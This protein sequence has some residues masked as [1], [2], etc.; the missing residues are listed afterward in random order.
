[1]IWDE[2]GAGQQ[3]EPAFQITED[4]QELLTAGFVDRRDDQ[5]RALRP[6]ASAG[7]HKRVPGAWAARREELAHP[8]GLRAEPGTRST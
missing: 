2:F 4:I 3:V 8:F 7:R 5:R 6:P 1:M